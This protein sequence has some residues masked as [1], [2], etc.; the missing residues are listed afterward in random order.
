MSPGRRLSI[1]LRVCGGLAVILL[2]QTYIR[3]PEEF[4]PE[5]LMGKQPVIDAADYIPAADVGDKLQPDELVLGVTLDGQS[6]AW[7]LNMLT[8]PQREIINDVVGGTPLAVT[9]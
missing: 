1:L 8:G 7:P 4:A 2:L 9:W 5:V 3:W 6:R